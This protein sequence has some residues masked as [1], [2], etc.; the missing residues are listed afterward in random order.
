MS[1]QRKLLLYSEVGRPPFSWMSPIS[2]TFE[3]PLITDWIL[4]EHWRRENNFH[5]SRSYDYQHLACSSSWSLV[6]EYPDSFVEGKSVYIDAIIPIL[7]KINYF[8]RKLSNISSAGI[9]DGALTYLF[10]K[11]ND[12]WFELGCIKSNS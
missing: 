8:C 7:F 2:Y 3:S 12:N 6:H 9:R 4:S 10:N 11:L 1:I 5:F